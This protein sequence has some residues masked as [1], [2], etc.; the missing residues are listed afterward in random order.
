MGTVLSMHF[1]TDHYGK[2]KG[3]AFVEFQTPQQAQNAIQILL[4][5]LV[6]NPVN[7]YFRRFKANLSKEP[8][9]NAH[10]P[11]RP[12]FVA[13]MSAMPA[14]MQFPPGFA[15]QGSPSAASVN[16][17]SN[18][19]GRDQ[20]LYN[21]P[22]QRPGNMAS[23]STPAAPVP[24]G[25]ALTSIFP[26]IDF[27]EKYLKATKYLPVPV[28]LPFTTPDKISETL[29]L[30]P[31]VEL[32]QLISNLKVSLSTGD[33]ARA[34]DVFQLSPQLAT[35]TAQALLLM[36]F[37]DE[38]VIQETMKFGGA[39]PQAA[40]P[41]P[42]LNAAGANTKGN[43]G[44]LNQYNPNL[45]GSAVP[46]SQGSHESY[47]GNMSQKQGFGQHKFNNRQGF[48]QQ[49][50][51]QSSTHTLQQNYALQNPSSHNYTQMPNSMLGN[52]PLPPPPPMQVPLAQGQGRW[53]HL[54]PSVQTKLANLPPNEANV[55]AEILA[56]PME[57]V[58]LLAP[59]RQNVIIGLKQQYM[60]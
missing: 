14:G 15:S 25:P 9:K 3:Y 53:P 19:Y 41:V 46:M 49:G 29:A 16:L 21:Q 17:N 33:M 34:A 30:L 18:S 12:P 58:Q 51:Y 10:I 47:R 7:G 32:I 37:I 13:S 38:T 42:V 22:T 59:D 8:N 26:K 52:N 11:N 28:K 55:V 24:A 48:Q 6:K 40:V 45:Y 60:Y 5:S 35:A 31:P 27:P 50:G 57:Q 2:N 1:L 36:G 56:M 23:L 4:Q 54:P 20:E 39:L 44:H 43:V